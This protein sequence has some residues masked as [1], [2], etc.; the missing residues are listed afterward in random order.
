MSDNSNTEG[1]TQMIIQVV[2]ERKPPSVREL[3]TLVEERL[4]VSEEEVLEAVLTLQS[5]GTI[6]LESQSPPTPP[7]PVT[8]LRTRQAVW[9]W[10]TV[11]LAAMTVA[12]LALGIYPSPV[13]RLIGLFAGG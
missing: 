8:Y 12:V 2:R 5:Q 1:L 3:V 7:K 10:A 9:Y 11:A 6:R 4:P 13:L